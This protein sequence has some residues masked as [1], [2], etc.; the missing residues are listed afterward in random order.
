V[1]RDVSI[2][3]TRAI[4][5]D[6]VTRALELPIDEPLGADAWLQARKR[7]F[8]TGLFQRVDLLME[9]LEARE[10]SP[11]QPMRAQLTVQEWP[12]FRLRYGF[13][14][15]EAWPAS[16]GGGRELVPGVSADLT[17]QTLFGRALSVGTAMRYDRRE[18]AGR[19][20]VSSPTLHGWPVQSALTFERSRVTIAGATLRTDRTGLAWEQ[21]LTSARAFRLSYS[22]R[23]ERN[24]TVDTAPLQPA[25]IPL[26]DVAV[27]VARLNAAA[28]FDTRDHPGNS[29]LGSLLSMSVDYA[30]EALGSDIRFVRSLVQ[31]YHFRPWHG[32]VLASAA[33]AGLAATLGGQELIP[34]ERFFAGGTRTVRGVREDSLGPRDV[35]GQPTGGRAMLVF[36]QE[37]RFPIYRWLGGAGFLDAGNVFSAP[38]A[39]D[40]GSLTGS[41]G[42]GLRLSTPFVLFRVDY[43]TPWTVPSSQRGGRWTFAIGQAF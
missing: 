6:V 35:L 4:D 3:G 38:S 30:P 11:E 16:G 23:F 31:A 13:R 7:V 40:L 28:A 27:N 5:A 18:R 29:T 41:L 9:R 33:R 37:V 21:R 22:Y 1:L 34:S 10:G 39:I 24:H 14:V 17:R 43:A 8:D 42:F 26:F 2:S 32:V 36:N 19:A 12:A 20:F 25:T 15:A